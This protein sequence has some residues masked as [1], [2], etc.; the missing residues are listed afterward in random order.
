MKPMR[1]SPYKPIGKKKILNEVYNTKMAFNNAKLDV[2]DEMNY[3]FNEL[4]E[5]FSYSK[6]KAVSVGT[7]VSQAFL[8]GINYESRKCADLRRDTDE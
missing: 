3:L 8:L 7:L 5:T 6:E 2:E 4:E 1:R